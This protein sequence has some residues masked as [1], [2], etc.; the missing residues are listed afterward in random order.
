MIVDNDDTKLEIRVQIFL[1]KSDFSIIKTNIRARSGQIRGR[2]A[3]LTK[4][5]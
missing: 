2:V 1:G 4:F 5:G 3:E